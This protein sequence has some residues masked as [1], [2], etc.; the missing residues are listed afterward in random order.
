[1]LR[2][3]LAAVFVAL[4]MMGITPVHAQFQT[5]NQ[6]PAQAQPRSAVTAATTQT[7][8]N[9]QA[10]P[11][12]EKPVKYEDINIRDLTAFTAL[13][14][15]VDLNNLSAFLEYLQITNCEIYTPIKNNQF[16]QQ[17]LQRSVLGQI[18][19]HQKEL[20]ELHLRIP[21]TFLTS[22][23]NFETQSLDIVDKDRMK[24][25]NSLQLFSPTDQICDNR[26][27]RYSRLPVLYWVKLNMPVSL[28]RI[29]IQRSLAE[30]ITAKLDRRHTNESQQIIYGNILVQIDPIAPTLKTAVSERVTG[31][32][33][34]Q[35][36]AIDLYLDHER[37]IPFKRLNYDVGL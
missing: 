16:R 20:H 33:Q 23:Y 37:K 34:G 14:K 24:R 29:P 5:Q 36:D 22:G 8:T 11:A 30:A 31:M 18:A 25:V 17:E 32:L 27:N 35:V 19:Q 2:L 3:F 4:L 13:T 21:V 6:A 15:G 12:K 7:Q 26:G 10:D 1:M 9:P 28:Y